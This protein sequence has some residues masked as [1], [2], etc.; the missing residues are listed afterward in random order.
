MPS[1]RSFASD[2]DI[3]SCKGCLKLLP[4]KTHMPCKGA[5]IY[6]HI[7]IHIHTYLPTY[8][9]TYLH[10]YIPTYLHTYIPTYLHTYIPTYLHTY[11]PT[12]LHTYIPTY[13]HTYTPTPTYL[14]T[15][16]HTYIPTYLH[17]YIP[18]YL[19]TYI[20]TYLHTYIPTYLH[21]YIPT[22]LHTIPCH[23][24][25]CH[26]MP[27]H[28]IPYHTSIH[29]YIHTLH[30][31]IIPYPFSTSLFWNFR[32]SKS[33]FL[34]RPNSSR[35]PKNDLRPGTSFERSNCR[36][37]QA[38]S[39]WKS[40]WAAAN[41]FHTISLQS[42][43]FLDE[44]GSVHDVAQLWH[45]STRHEA[46]KLCPLDP[47]PS[48]AATVSFHGTPEWLSCCLNMV[49][50]RWIWVPCSEQ[51]WTNNIKRLRPKI[52]V[53]LGKRW[54]IITRGTIFP[55]NGDSCCVRLFS[56][57]SKVSDSSVTG[58]TCRLLHVELANVLFGFQMPRNLQTSQLVGGFSPLINR[59]VN[60]DHYP[61]LIVRIENKN[62][63]PP[64]SQWQMQ[65]SLSLQPISLE[66]SGRPCWWWTGHHRSPFRVACLACL[67]CRV[68][69]V[70]TS[71]RWPKNHKGQ[72]R[73]QPRPGRR[74]YQ[75]SLSVRETM[76]T[77][78]ETQ[79]ART[80]CWW[81]FFEIASAQATCTKI[82]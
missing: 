49:I 53:Y 80:K 42:H 75:R 72:K 11:I 81:I 18:T 47:R 10:T 1:S 40:G 31:Q 64:T 24:M 76:E 54:T 21:T 23:A 39:A 19:H 46:K 32:G 73:G 8:I 4:I 43:L 13:L 36:D 7:Y 78:A 77:M 68:S 51:T 58:V 67:A 25:P 59:T 44:I 5:Y 82:N 34:M 45:R 12:Y 16:L 74:T 6:I 9:P 30:L 57:H 56:C 60:W 69:E 63:K 48:T 62:I 71:E 41:T 27:Y 66:A 3:C 55:A 17:T 14:P 35:V 26:D 29:T 50:N 52:D 33:M 2:Q 61:V 79:T 70:H 28:T 22:Y 20:P 65:T 37:F 38:N 15:Y